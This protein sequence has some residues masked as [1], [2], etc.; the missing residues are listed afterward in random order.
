M[1]ESALTLF[2]YGFKRAIW[3]S[4]ALPV[5]I[6]TAVVRTVVALCSD[7]GPFERPTKKSHS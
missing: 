5:G 1:N 7:E 3:L 6:V 4:V 2:L